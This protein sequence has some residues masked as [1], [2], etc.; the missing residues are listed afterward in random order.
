VNMMRIRPI[1]TPASELGFFFWQHRGCPFGV[2]RV[3]LTVG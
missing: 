2:K 3:V 1:R